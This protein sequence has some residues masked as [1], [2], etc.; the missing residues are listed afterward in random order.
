MN[1]KM[2]QNENPVF[3]AVY[4]NDLTKK[5]MK[6]Q[7]VAKCTNLNRERLLKLELLFYFEV[8]SSG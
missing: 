3:N 1:P 5:S 4:F 6:L 7:F 2:F 8:Y